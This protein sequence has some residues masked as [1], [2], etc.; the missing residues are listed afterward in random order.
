MIALLLSLALQTSAP[1]PQAPDFAALEETARH[2]DR[3][4]TDALFAFDTLADY[5]AIDRDL[6]EKMRSAVDLRNRIAYGYERVDHIRLQSE[7]QDR[8]GALRS[9]LGLVSDIS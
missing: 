3:G 5:D 6:T 2:P 9:F 1:P 4:R 7:S 8:V